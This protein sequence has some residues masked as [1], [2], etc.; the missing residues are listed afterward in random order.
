MKNDKFSIGFLSATA[1]LLFA[2]CIFVKT[3]SAKAELSIKDRDW[4]ITT[5]AL[6]QG[7]E[8]LY[9]TDNRSE[10]MAVFAWDVAQRSLV[11]KAVG[12]VANL[13]LAR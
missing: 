12:P 3:P 10:K 6:Q 2:A 11:L 8:A 13:F 5:A 1:L 4:I 7:G 9:I